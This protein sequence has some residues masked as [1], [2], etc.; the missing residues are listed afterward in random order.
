MTV[1]DQQALF[2][3]IGSSYKDYGVSGFGLPDLRERFPITASADDLGNLLGQKLGSSTS[4]LGV[5]E[6]VSHRHEFLLGQTPDVDI[7][8]IAETV[9]SLV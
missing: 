2:S 9:C 5:D 4:Q 8:M 7:D 6:L 3:I 1:T